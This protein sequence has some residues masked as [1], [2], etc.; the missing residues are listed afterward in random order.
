MP[1]PPVPAASLPRTRAE[2]TNYLETS[3]QADV[4]AFL[5][6]LKKLGAAISLGSM[7]KTT[8]GR[9]L[10]YAIASRPLV[11]TPSEARRLGR[12]IVYV[13]GNIHSGEVEG[14]EALQALLR[15]LVLSP[16]RNVLDSIVLIAL[17]NYNADGN[18]K[19]APQRTNRGSQNG[20]EM[21][22]TRGALGPVNLNRDYV[23]ADLPETRAALALFDTWDPE[24]YVDLHTTDGSFMGYALTYSPSLNPAAIFGGVYARDSM[25]PELRVRMRT[26]HNFETFDYGEYRGGTDATRQW[27]TYEHTPRYGSNYYG[28]RGR[29][30][31]LSEAYSHDPFQRRVASTYAFVAEILSMVAEQRSRIMALC[32]RADETTIAWGLR[33]GASPPIAI[34]SE[35]TRTPFTG[36]LLV[37]SLFVTPGDTAHYQPDLRTRPGTRMGNVHALKGTIFDRFT[38]VLSRTL[39]GGWAL[40]AAHA[41]AVKLLR[42]HGIIVDQL[43]AARTVSAELYRID[44]VFNG[45]ST[46]EYGHAEVDSVRGAWRKE[47]KTLP[48]GTFM[49]SAAQ[50]LGILALYL[51]DPQSDE[52]LASWNYFDKVMPK[53][54]D[55]PV[56][57]I[58]EPLGIP[59]GK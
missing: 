14:K 1:V 49:I 9:D 39:P 42:L 51:L 59:K 5:D 22:G 35:M 18:E 16:K 48:A 56:T 23:K 15:D 4:V 11:S 58:M 21:V 20:P 44:S 7:G 50:P 36:D 32:K 6:S 13:E 28:L 19:L 54:A 29:V 45:R 24:V 41:D 34:R 26:R 52:S 10:V 37:D 25:L 27:R 43:P 38:P 47:N 57:R 55:F 30:G 2:R 12:P 40:P 3:S 31:I 53:G 17:P 8:E 33:P 46:A